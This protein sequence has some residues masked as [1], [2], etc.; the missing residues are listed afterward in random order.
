MSDS[1]VN[2]YS[3]TEIGGDICTTGRMRVPFDV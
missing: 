1:G 2:K 3:N